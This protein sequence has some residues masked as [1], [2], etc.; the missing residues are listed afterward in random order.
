V[1][2]GGDEVIEQ[3]GDFRSWHKADIALLLWHVRYW[4]MNG[5]GFQAI[6]V[7]AL[8][9]APSPAKQALNQFSRPLA[10]A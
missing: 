4:G 5:P 7:A 1:F 3:S 9:S 6:R 10:D 8:P 2:A